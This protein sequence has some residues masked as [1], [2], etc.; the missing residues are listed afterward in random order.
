[1]SSSH[2]CLFVWLNLVF[3]GQHQIHEIKYI[4]YICVNILG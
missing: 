2:F 3:E 1:M 4:Q